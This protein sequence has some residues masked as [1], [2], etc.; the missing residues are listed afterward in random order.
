M[1]IVLPNVEAE[2]ECDE[3]GYTDDGFKCDPDG[4]NGDDYED[5]GVEDYGSRTDS[6]GGSMPKIVEFHGVVQV[7]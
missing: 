6:I 5:Y 2:P 7:C 3:Y 4:G 1:A